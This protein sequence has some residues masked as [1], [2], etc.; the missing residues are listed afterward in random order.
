MPWIN[1]EGIECPEGT[2]W[3]NERKTQPTHPDYTGSL[4]LPREVVNDLV[5]QMNRGEQ[6]PKIEISGWRKTKKD[7][8]MFLSIGGK[9]PWV[10]PES[11]NAQ[12]SNQA[13]QPAGQPDPTSDGKIP[14]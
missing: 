1:N 14:F 7:G 13:G 2:L 11:A 10:K 6:F 5:A 8:T 9:K 12:T 4:E 3:Q